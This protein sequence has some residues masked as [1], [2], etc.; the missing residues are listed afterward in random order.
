MQK[1]ALRYIQMNV[2]KLERSNSAV[3]SSSRTSDGGDDAE[4]V[5]KQ[6]TAVHHITSGQDLQIHIQLWTDVPGRLGCRQLCP[7]AFDGLGGLPSSA[8][9]GDTGGPVFQFVVGKTYSLSFLVQNRDLASPRR[10]PF[11]DVI[12]VRPRTGS[13]IVYSTRAPHRVPSRERV[14]VRIGVGAQGDSKHV[15]PQVRESSQ[16]VWWGEISWL[17]STFPSPMCDDTNMTSLESPGT[18]WVRPSL[19]RHPRPCATVS[20]LTRSTALYGERCGRERPARVC[21][22]RCCCRCRTCRGRCV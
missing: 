4:S 19:R 6:L 18:M 9:A 14:Q 12:E 13:H 2:H 3:S 11:S 21:R 8:P 20:V 10:M 17:P 16:Q 1:D 22:C 5:H 7:M 15:Q